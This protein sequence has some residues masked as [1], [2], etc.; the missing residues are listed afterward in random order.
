MVNAIFILTIGLSAALLLG[1]LRES[2]KEAAYA[3]T[4]AAL[5]S[6]VWIAIGWIW[7]F[8]VEGVASIEVFTAGTEPPFA[9]NL[10]IGLAESV[11]ILLVNMSSLLSA[12][13]MKQTL[14]RLG[15]RAMAILLVFTMALSGIIL[16]RDVFSL[17]RTSSYCNSWT[18]PAF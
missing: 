1:F 11:L 18:Y 6:L 5:T 12:L 8:S 13:Y 3:I 7:F 9:I 2:W 10:R 17:F 16:T 4:L 15:R 14:L